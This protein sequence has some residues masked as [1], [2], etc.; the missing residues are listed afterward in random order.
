MAGVVHVS[1]YA[2]ILRQGAFAADV[3]RVAPISLRYGASQYAVHR[4]NDDRYKILMMTW[5]ESKDDWY[6]F[7]DGPEMIAF[8]RRNSG[9]FQIPLTYI[10]HEELV[11]GALGPEVPLE[12][13]EPAP[14]PSPTA[15]V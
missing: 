8:R 1:W 3:C 5:F 13:A 15:A 4:S 12:P 11:A 9:R 7:W 14:V 10:W 6:R 2:S